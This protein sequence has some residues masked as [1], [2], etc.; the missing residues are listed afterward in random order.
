MEMG[1]CS[2]FLHI[3]FRFILSAPVLLP[4][5][6]KLFATPI[7]KVPGSALMTSLTCGKIITAK[8]SLAVVTRHAT[9]S[10]RRRVMIQRLRSGNLVSRHSYSHAVTFNA[11]ET[12]SLAVFCMTKANCKCRG[13]FSRSIKPACR[14]A[15]SAR[16]NITI[17]GLRSR[18][19]TLITGDVRVQAIWNCHCHALTQRPVTTGAHYISHSHMARMIEL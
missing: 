18:T 1:L 3:G 14:V 7:S 16:R 19:V 12:L 2:R 8:R 6:A 15:D 11:S 10:V 4:N 17:A 9:Q 5:A 13:G